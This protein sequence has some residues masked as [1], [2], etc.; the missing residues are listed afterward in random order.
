MAGSRKSL[1]SQ[2]FQKFDS[3]NFQKKIKT[4]IYRT[5][6]DWKLSR[7]GFAMW[8]VQV[9][10]LMFMT[11]YGYYGCIDLDSCKPIH[12]YIYMII[13]DYLAIMFI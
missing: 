12:V 7:I 8:G 3:E 5:L 10:F 13:Y 2:F 4:L 6:L 11:I 9:Q 1:D